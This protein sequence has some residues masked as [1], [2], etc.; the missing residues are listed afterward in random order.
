MGLS[1]KHN[2]EIKYLAALE[3]WALERSGMI[4]KYFFLNT[5]H[6]QPFTSYNGKR[7]LKKIK[8]PSEIYWI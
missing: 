8:K 4:L 5:S 6:L 2:Q 3:F 1:S 7:F